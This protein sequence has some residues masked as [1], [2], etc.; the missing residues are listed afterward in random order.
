MSV[1]LL[2]ALLLVHFLTHLSLNFTSKYDFVALCYY[3]HLLLCIVKLGIA[4]MHRWDNISN[5]MFKEP[6]SKN[7]LMC[8]P[9]IRMVLIVGKH[10]RLFLFVAYPIHVLLNRLATNPCTA[11]PVQ[12]PVTYMHLQ[13]HTVLSAHSASRTFHHPANP[14]YQARSSSSF[15]LSKPPVTS[16]LM[17]SNRAISITVPGLWNDL[18]P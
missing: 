9:T 17:F 11:N 2:S 7:R 8:F 15:T 14:L 4:S 3:A 6:S 12:G 13:L 1:K 18:P 10:V 16:H 5:E